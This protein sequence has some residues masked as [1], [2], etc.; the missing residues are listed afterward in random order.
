MPSTSYV[1]PHE[2]RAATFGFRRCLSRCCQPSSVQG[3]RTATRVTGSE[4]TC[5]GSFSSRRCA[6]Q[7]SLARRVSSSRSSPC[8]HL[9]LRFFVA[10]FHLLLACSTLKH[11][12][13][14]H[15]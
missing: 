4:A 13:Q 2:R 8:V 14:R 5:A 15:L 9:D 10:E 7:C 12:Q 1:A 6:A 11:A 3:S